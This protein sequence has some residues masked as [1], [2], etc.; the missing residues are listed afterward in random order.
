MKS[1]EGDSNRVGRP[2]IGI[3]GRCPEG[4]SHSV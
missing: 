4:R 3:D 2:S 1:A